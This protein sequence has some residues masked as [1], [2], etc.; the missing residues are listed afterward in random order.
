MRTV[1]AANEFGRAPKVGGDMRGCRG[2]WHEE[3]GISRVICYLL[4]VFSVCICVALLIIV[5]RL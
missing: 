2:P 1:T 4:A 3:D 5:E